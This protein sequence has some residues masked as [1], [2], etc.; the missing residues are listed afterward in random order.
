MS[1]KIVVQCFDAVNYLMKENTRFPLWDSMKRHDIIEHFTSGKNVCSDVSTKR[2]CLSVIPLSVLHDQIN[3]AFCV[4]NFIKL[5]NICMPSFLQDLNL[6][7]HSSDVCLVANSAFLQDL[8]CQLQIQGK[9]FMNQT[10]RAQHT[11]SP[12]GK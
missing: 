3:G 5:D 9:A 2:K 8:N 4:K 11:F 12:V 10:L 1:D 7:V 6:S